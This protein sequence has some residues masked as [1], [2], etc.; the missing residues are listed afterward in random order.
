MGNGDTVINCSADAK[1][2]EAFC[3]PY[4]NAKNASVEMNILDSRNGIANNL[5]AKIN[6]TSHK[7]VIKTSA[8]EYIPETMAIK[9]SVWEGYGN[10][11]ENAKMHATD[12]KLNNQTSVEVITFNG[13]KNLDVNSI[14]KV[15]KATELENL[16]NESNRT[17][18]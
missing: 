14:G 10:F 2:G 11:D 12:I 3:I 4:T 6:G 9:L 8:S 13:T 1:Y 5:L 16:V 17:K 18:R 15:R 7:V